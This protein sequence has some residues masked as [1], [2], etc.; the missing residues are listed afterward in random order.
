MDGAQSPTPP[1]LRDVEA[2]VVQRGRHKRCAVDASQAKNQGYWTVMALR[3]DRYGP[4]V[5]I[6]LDQLTLNSAAE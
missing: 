3:R 5:Y 1:G 6:F 4:M 2:R